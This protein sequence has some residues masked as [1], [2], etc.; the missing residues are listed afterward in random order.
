MPPRHQN[1][2]WRDAEMLDCAVDSLTRNILEVTMHAYR[3]CLVEEEVEPL[4]TLVGDGRGDNL[5]CRHMTPNIS[6]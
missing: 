3:N 2:T 1:T 6:R 4:V 5:E